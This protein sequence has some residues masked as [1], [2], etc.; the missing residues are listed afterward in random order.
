MMNGLASSTT[1][2]EPWIFVDVDL[3]E[4][5]RKG[6]RK[7][8]MKRQEKKFQSTHE[9]SAKRRKKRSS[10]IEIY[11]EKVNR[12]D[13]ITEEGERCSRKSLDY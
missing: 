12:R 1:P 11:P 5:L 3:N 7:I 4:Q 8:K 9:P 2:L 6:R 13:P 10:T